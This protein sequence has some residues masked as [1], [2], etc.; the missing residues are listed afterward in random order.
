MKSEGKIR[1]V[2]GALTAIMA[3]EV[4]H[5]VAR[6]GAEKLGPFAL[7]QLLVSF[8]RSSSPLLHS[9]VTYLFSR[10]FSRAMESEAD[11]IGVVLL[12]LAK[13]DPHLAAEMFKALQGTTPAKEFLS[14]HPADER[15]ARECLALVQQLE[16][17]GNALEPGGGFRA[18]V[19][20]LAEEERRVRAALL[21]PQEV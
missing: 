8:L 18:A 2:E 21:P 7:V 6:H 16:E 13:H 1:S 5:A 14:T 3:H 4:G 17:D 15:R 20:H 11:A 10:P 19:R 9:T 12:A